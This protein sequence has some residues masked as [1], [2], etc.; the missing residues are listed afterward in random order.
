MAPTSKTVG[1]RAGTPSEIFYERYAI[2]VTLTM[3]RE[4]WVNFS[5]SYDGE[6]EMC[7]FSGGAHKICQPYM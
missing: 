6:R 1:A 2:L 5:C 3:M 7:H 4:R